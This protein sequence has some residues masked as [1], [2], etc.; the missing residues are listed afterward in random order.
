MNFTEVKTKL[1]FPLN[2]SRQPVGNM[3]A[4]KFLF[5]VPK[6]TLGPGLYA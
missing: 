3:A 6:N 5:I 4:L 1:P 2:Q